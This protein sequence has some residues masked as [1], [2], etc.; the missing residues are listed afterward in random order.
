M[1]STIESWKSKSWFSAALSAFGLVVLETLAF[2]LTLF[3]AN[4][5]TAGALLLIVVV[6]LSALGT[7]FSA[8][9]LSVVAVECLADLSSPPMFSF[10]ILRQEDIVAITAFLASSM[11]VTGIAARRRQL[12]ERELR[13]ARIELARFARVS[14]LGELTASIA[15][16][17]NQPLA[18]LVSNSDACRRWLA[19][20]PPNIERANEALARVIR[21]A[22]L[23]R[24]VVERIRGLAKNGPVERTAVRLDGPVREVIL[25]ARP[26][27]EQHKIRL[28]AQFADGLPP[29]WADRIQLQQV[30]LNLVLN[31]IEFI[32]R[33]AMGLET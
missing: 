17:V 33:R 19:S 3:D 24:K 15:H 18:G 21:D 22:D 8:V 14:L 9:F 16:E 5:A 28:E 30:C 7:Y 31:A 26:E 2:V 23:A 27:A 12:S 6:L 29:V 25:L 10:R 20:Q 13:R 4:I 1:F 32:R 11:I